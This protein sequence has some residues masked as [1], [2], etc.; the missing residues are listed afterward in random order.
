MGSQTLDV[1]RARLLTQVDWSW[2]KEAR[3][4]GWFGLHDGMR[5]LELGSGPGFVTEQLLQMLPNST[6]IALDSNRASLDWSKDYLRGKGAER[7]QFVEAPAVSTGL[8]DNSVDFA[9][10]RYLF[11]HLPDPVGAVREALRVLKP[12]GKLVIIDNDKGMYGI[13]DPP[14]AELDVMIEKRAQ[15]QAARGGDAQIG[16]KLWRVLQAA[17]FQ[18]LDLEAV[19][20]YSDA[21]GMDAFKQHFSAER[22]QPLIQAGLAT[23]QDLERVAASLNTFYADPNALILQILLMAYGKKPV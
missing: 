18:N 20:F 1:E 12:G 13:V 4:L 17:G 22:V 8:P 14:I 9:I 21:L 7:V 3:I 16:R 15:V 11:Q 2:Q 19:V 10:A 5:V 6:I 23:E